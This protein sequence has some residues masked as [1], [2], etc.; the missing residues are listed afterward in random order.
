MSEKSYSSHTILQ[1]P[2]LEFPILS[3]DVYDGSSPG[4]DRVVIGSIAEDYSSAAYCAV[5]TH[6]G[7]RRNGFAECA[8][9]TLNMRGK[10]EYKAGGR[11]RKLLQEIDMETNSAGALRLN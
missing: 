5:I 8:D 1:K 11:E 10:G 7:E 6:D 2:Y 4:A 9:D 3:G